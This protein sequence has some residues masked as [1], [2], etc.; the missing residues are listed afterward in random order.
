MPLFFLMQL[1]IDESDIFVKGS[2]ISKGYIL[3]KI[4]IF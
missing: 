2:D 3:I 4:I 1:F